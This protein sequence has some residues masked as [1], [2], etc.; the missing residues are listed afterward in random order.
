MPFA[1][2]ETYDNWKKNWS[3]GSA[4]EEILK[5]YFLRAGY[6]VV[7]GVPY[8]VEGTDLTDIDLWLY[9]IVA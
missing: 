4:L 7:R 8:R 5:D 3:K 9:P 2:G 1:A 6:F